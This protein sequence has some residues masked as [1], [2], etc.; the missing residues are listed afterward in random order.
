MNAVIGAVD[1]REQSAHML[2]SAN[3]QCANEVQKVMVNGGR[4][5]TPNDEEDG[6]QH[7]EGEEGSAGSEGQEEENDEGHLDY[8]DGDKV[9]Q[10]LYGNTQ[11]LPENGGGAELNA[12]G[13][14]TMGQKEV[15]N[16]DGPLL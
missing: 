12:A 16:S 2:P 14:A 11:G 15:E 8:V 9:Q 1:G 7:E 13:Y 3:V 4:V 10:I 6:E 5:G